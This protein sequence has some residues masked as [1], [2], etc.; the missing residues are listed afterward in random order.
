M[1]SYDEKPGIQA[2]ANITE[3]LPPMKITKQSA[4]TMNT[5]VLELFPAC[6][7]RPANRRGKDSTCEGSA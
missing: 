3:D 6:R 5:N 1:Y 7:D 2:I 4:E